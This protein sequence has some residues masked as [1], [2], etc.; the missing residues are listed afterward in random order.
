M[1][2]SSLLRKPSALFRRELILLN[3]NLSRLLYDFAVFAISAAV[4]SAFAYVYSGNLYP[5]FLAVPFVGLVANYV[6]GVYGRY[7]VGGGSLKAIILSVSAA[8]VAGFIFGTTGDAATSLLWT[9]LVWGPLVLPRMFLNLNRRASGTPMSRTLTKAIKGGGPVLVVG[10]GGYIG[11][12]V[13]HQLLK[14]GYAVRVLD[15]L[16]YGRDSLAEFAENQNFELIDGDVTDISKLV[17]ATDGA[18]A[19]VHLAGLVGDPACA[20][21]ENYTLHSNVIVTKMLKEVAISAGVQRFI[22]ASSCSVYGA[23]DDVVDETSDL[24]PVSLYARTKIASEKELL[25]S[26]SDEFFVTI[27]RFATVFGHSRRPRFDLVGNLFTAQA[28]NDGKITVFGGDS[29]RPFIHV[30]DIAK[31][32]VLTLKA[33]PFR[34]QGQVLNVGDARLNMTIGDLADKV[35]A[36][37]S[38][39][40]AVEIVSH[41]DSADR[42]NYNVSFDKIKRVIGFTAD[43][44]IE[45]GVQE[46][47][48]EFKRGTYADYKS[49]KFS[50]LEITK[51]VVVDFKNP[52]NTENLYR[53]YSV[54][55][56]IGG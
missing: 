50:N 23:N 5:S 14:E 38:A 39:D 29:W 34:V 54:A 35:Q 30:A 43:R 42:R 18:S 48:A 33:N 36:V 4:A 1:A 51:Q 56:V 40:R 47:V 13:V 49:A 22:F 52:K 44:M 8:L 12:H 3:S 41:K 11:S 21:D 46:M 55:D 28:F 26:V 37:I 32:I 17:R 6:V 24:N 20:L 9:S 27:L 19:V 31:A 53:P 2:L 10:G 15:S 16:F 45:D 7:R 25:S